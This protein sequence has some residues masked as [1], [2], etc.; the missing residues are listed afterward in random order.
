MS[1]LKLAGISKEI[2]GN[3]VLKDISF[4]L[5]RFRKLAIA[6]ATG[7]GKTTLLK[8]VAGLIKPDA[9]KVFFEEVRLPG[10]DEQLIPG[11]PAIGWLS[12]QF[13]LRNNYRVEEVLEYANELTPGEASTIFNV[14]RVDHLLKRRTDQLSG[15]EKQ[16][17]AITRLLITSPRLL[18]LDEPFSNLD[19]FHKQLMK[20][21]IQDI[22]EKLEITCILIS[23]DPLDTLSW[24]DEILV[25][26][27]G[28]LLQYGAPAEVYKKPVDEYTAALFGTYNLLSPAL[29]HLLTG[30][31]IQGNQ[32]QSLIMRPENFIITKEGDDVLKGQIKNIQYFGAYREVEVLLQGIILKVRADEGSFSKGEEVCIR[33][34]SDQQ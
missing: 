13:E 12:Q 27:K 4:S 25:M 9:G 3:L 5:E 32:L 21:V 31:T 30:K 7:S 19:M 1:L 34:K 10:P 24:A 15:G 33:L 26:N 23:H 14:C 29:L 17:I 20:S 18:L 2:Q 8:I 11:H 6:G 22:G 16:R 28:E